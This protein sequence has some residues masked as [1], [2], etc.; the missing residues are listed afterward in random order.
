MATTSSTCLPRRPG[1]TGYRWAAAGL[2]VLTVYGGLLPFHFTPRP[3]TEAVESFR[4]IP[5]FDPW[6]LDA[7]G[8]WIVSVVQYATLSFLLMAA[9]CADSKRPAVPMAA[10]IG[11][12]CAALAIAIEFT[13]QFFP[14]RTVSWN[15]VALESVGGAMGVVAWIA[16]GP[17]VVKWA[18]RLTAVTTVSDLARR[19][20]PAYLA[21]LLI[22]ELMPFDLI[23]G[24]AELKS[25][26]LEGKIILIPFARR[27]DAAAIAKAALNVIAFVPMGMLPTLVG[28]RSRPSGD[29]LHWPRVAL[30]GP[31]L[32]E[33]LQLFTY[34]RAFD[35]T[36]ILTGMVGVWG[37]WWLGQPTRFR[38]VAEWMA[39]PRLGLLGPV[40][41]LVWLA[42]VVYV[43]WHPF[44]FTV[45]P[46][47][48]AAD[49]EDFPEYGMRRMTL[50]PFVDYYWGSKYNA[51][52]QFV[53]KG[54]SFLPAGVLVALSAREVFQLGAARAAVGIAL[55]TAAMLQ[56]GRYFLPGH[57]PSVTDILIAGTA[58]WF[59]F[60]S[61]Q[62]VRSVLWT[63]TALAT[64]RAGAPTPLRFITPWRDVGPV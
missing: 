13:Q 63:E 39:A 23:V 15:D 55:L 35:A 53:R 17:R 46:M 7:R 51:L 28:M 37:G 29:Q 32:V 18:R 30:A 25:K 56:L 60:R 4:Q 24:G 44:D 19:L 1:A 26:Y 21:G 6:D 52:D 57:M 54:I 45:D 33:V 41:W 2:L 36:D 47:C 59:G 58:A 40:A 8:D 48:F 10:I 34:S 3:L 16:A 11:L 38:V 9:A 62:Y 12:A 61:T 49:S 27:F 5:S 14:P 20:I 42:V 22:V 64:N 31:V 50:A 43:H